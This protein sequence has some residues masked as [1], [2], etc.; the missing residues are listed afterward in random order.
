M[1]LGLAL[2]WALLDPVSAQA[3]PGDPACAPEKALA[4]T[5]TAKQGDEAVPLVATHELSVVAEWPGA[6]RNPTLEVPAGVRV[7][8]T[9]P[10]RVRLIVPV[11]A[12]LAV[13]ASW[14]QG[15]PSDGE[16][17]CV[18]S[19]TTALPITAAKPP[20]A[21][22][23]LAGRRPDLAS[24]AVVPDREAADLSPLE[25]SVRLTTAAR[26]PSARSK[27]RT[28]P[29]AMR[30]SERV[31][32]R[33]RIP[34]PSLLGLAE[35]N[36]FYNLTRGPGRLFTEVSTLWGASYRNGRVV[37]RDL[38]SRAPLPP[39]QPYLAVAPDGV[40]IDVYLFHLPRPGEPRAF[41]YGIGYDIQV[42]QS[43]RLVARL[44]RALRW[45]LSPRGRYHHHLVRAENG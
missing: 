44:R 23:D 36:R 12:S 9:A 11:S 10:K 37:K 13:T 43:G 35:S 22:Y 7:L 20:R 15:D 38:S 28:M 39:A 8:G 19:Q 1:P 14:E 6:V 42:R 16:P 31:G 5:F 34:S 3:A 17:R 18:A 2:V 30:P 40:R 25:V 45:G 27:A 41:E 4:V 33:R 24:L 32:Y 21:L 26:F 29:V